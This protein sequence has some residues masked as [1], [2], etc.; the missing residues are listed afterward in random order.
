M[1]E[2]TEAKS[3]ERKVLQKFWIDGL[4]VAKSPKKNMRKEN[5]LLI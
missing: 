5:K 4:Q 3:L 1:Q 2:K